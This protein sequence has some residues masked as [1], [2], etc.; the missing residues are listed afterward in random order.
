LRTAVLKPVLKPGGV[1]SLTRGYLGLKKNATTL[2]RFGY[3]V[4]QV[5]ETNPPRLMDVTGEG[6]LY[7]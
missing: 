6:L 4:P 3:H 7:D 1:Y 5:A 2:L